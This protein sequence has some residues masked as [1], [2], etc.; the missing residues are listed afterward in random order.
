MMVRKVRRAARLSGA[1]SLVALL[2][3]CAG[4]APTTYDLHAPRDGLSAS[5]SK[6]ILVVGEPQALAALDSSRI[7]ITTS[8]GALNY[9]PGGQW[10]DRLPKL[11]QVRM[12]EA[13]ENANRMAGV[14]RPGDRLV[15]VAQLNSELRRFG[16]EEAT[17]EAVVEIAVKIV[18]DRSGQIRAGEIFT[19][20]VA[21]SGG[22]TAA[23]ASVALDQAAQAIM[24]DIVAWVSRRM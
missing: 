3:A 10:S 4:S 22:T 8:D 17:G 12:I 20:R 19:R 18:D 6:R 14:G 16:I 23:G 15:P 24:R 9:L 2:A 1:F 11:L 5:R 21:A 13:F 7:L